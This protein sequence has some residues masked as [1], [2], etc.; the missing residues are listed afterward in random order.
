MFCQHKSHKK[1]KE[2]FNI[3]TFDACK[4]IKD[5][6]EARGD[7]DMIARIGDADLIAMGARYHNACRTKS[8]SKANINYTSFKEASREDI[9]SEAF[10]DLMIP[11][12]DGIKQGKAY[13]LTSLL[14][15]YKSKLR[16]RGISTADSYTSQRLKLR[17]KNY[18]KDRIVF[19]EQHQQNKSQLMYS[20]QISP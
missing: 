18:F 12:E 14:T 5:A 19:H 1:N 4:N 2:M 8:T 13:E 20:S 7:V 9:Y 16:E 17:L 15:K 10:A 6:A 3:S 11:V